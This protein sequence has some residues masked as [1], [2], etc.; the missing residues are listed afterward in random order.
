M[1]AAF[2]FL[3]SE[4]VHVLSSMRYLGLEK[5]DDSSLEDSSLTS[6]SAVLIAFSALFGCP[7]NTRSPLVENT[8][9]WGMA[10]L[11]LGPETP[12]VTVN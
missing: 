7:L 6:L 4:F 5:N 10:L 1:R 12:F 11:R 2:N 8:A 3:P 9:I